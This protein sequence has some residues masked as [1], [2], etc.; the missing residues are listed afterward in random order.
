MRRV[1]PRWAVAV[2]A[3]ALFVLLCATLTPAWQGKAEVSDVP[4]YEVLGALIES[5]RVPYRDVR[6]V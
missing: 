1:D 2:G 3:V 5:G 6:I 4:H